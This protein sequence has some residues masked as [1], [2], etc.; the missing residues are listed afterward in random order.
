[1]VVPVPFRWILAEVMTFAADTLKMT[2]PVPLMPPGPQV[3][4]ESEWICE[5]VAGFLRSGA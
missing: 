5:R 3:T 2:Q 4:P 1:M